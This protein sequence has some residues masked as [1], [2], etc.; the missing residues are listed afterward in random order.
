MEAYN[1]RDSCRPTQLP[2]A[3]TSTKTTETVYHRTTSSG[4]RRRS[5]MNGTFLVSGTSHSEQSYWKRIKRSQTTS[6][7]QDQTLTLSARAGAIHSSHDFTFVDRTD[8]H[9]QSLTSLHKEQTH[10]SDC[11][12]RTYLKDQRI[13]LAKENVMSYVCTI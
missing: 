2:P 10:I 6:R 12:C 8:R 1:C 11:T 9:T 5:C 4:S 7:I 13:T 3:G